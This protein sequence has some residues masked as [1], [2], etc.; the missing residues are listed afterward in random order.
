MSS[1]SRCAPELNYRNHLRLNLLCRKVIVVDV[2]GIKVFTHHNCDYFSIDRQ[3]NPIQRKTKIEN[4]AIINFTNKRRNNRNRT[5]KTPISHST[6]NT[7]RRIFLLQLISSVCAHTYHDAGFIK[8]CF[9][10]DR[11]LRK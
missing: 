11:V 2:D 8:N 5:H 9:L 1:H 4:N 10:L 7:L 3:H 6:A